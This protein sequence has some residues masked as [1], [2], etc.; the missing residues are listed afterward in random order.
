MLESA[1]RDLAFPTMTC[2]LTGERFKMSD[3]IELQE[4]ATGFA[5]SG[6]V[7]AKRYKPS[8]T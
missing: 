6:Q 1:A 2:P 5:A 7:E 4:A 8:M 3:V